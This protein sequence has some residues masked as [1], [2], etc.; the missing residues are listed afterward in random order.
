MKKIYLN[1]HAS[2]VI[3]NELKSRGI[4]QE[5][6]A[7]DYLLVRYRTFQYWLSGKTTIPFEKIDL[8]QKYLNLNIRDIFGQIP[9]E[10]KK[11]TTSV[12]HLFRLAIKKRVLIAVRE[13]FNHYA[14]YLTNKIH[15]HPY[16][17]E[18]HFQ[19]LECKAS[20]KMNYYTEISIII[21]NKIIPT[22]TVFTIGFIFLP[23]RSRFDYGFMKVGKDY[24]EVRETFTKTFSEQIIKINKDKFAKTG[25]LFTLATWISEEDMIFVIKSSDAEFCISKDEPA[26]EINDTD[27]MMKNGKIVFKKAVWHK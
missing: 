10:Y 25:E 13:N 1:K 4:T 20:E 21:E 24:L 16:P 11:T 18:E 8:I 17:V 19:I 14:E 9:Q 3:R 15:I 7:E 22:D 26:L 12:F 5:D 23:S 27:L 2:E 6:F